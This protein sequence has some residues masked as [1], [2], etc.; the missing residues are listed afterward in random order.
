MQIIGGKW[1]ICII[2]ALRDGP[3]RPSEL[4]KAI[5][6]ATERVINQKIKELLNHKII[7][8][9]IYAQQPPRSEYFLTELGRSVFPLIDSL[10]DWGE[11]NRAVYE[12]VNPEN[13]SR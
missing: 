3:L 13:I 8:R 10:D 2:D 9:T 12:D 6:D 11:K 1:K 5:P 7:N 4:F